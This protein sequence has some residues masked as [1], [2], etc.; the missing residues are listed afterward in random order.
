MTLGMLAVLEA[1]V[2]GLSLG[3]DAD[4]LVRAQGGDLVQPA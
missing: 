4:E 2:A 3:V 1:A